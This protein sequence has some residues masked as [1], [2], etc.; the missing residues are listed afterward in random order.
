[1]SSDTPC[2]HF[3]IIFQVCFSKCRNI[4]GKDTSRVELR[5]SENIWIF[6]EKESAAHG[7]FKIHWT[8]DRDNCHW[9]PITVPALRVL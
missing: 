5:G 8:L 9:P 7:K 6:D 2:A 3:S 1:M 4:A